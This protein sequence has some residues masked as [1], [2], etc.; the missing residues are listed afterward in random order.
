MTGK[1]LIPTSNAP[2]DELEELFPKFKQARIQD[3]EDALSELV[4]W[5]DD[6]DSEK[7]QELFSWFVKSRVIEYKAGTRKPEENIHEFLEIMDREGVKCRY[8]MMTHREEIICSKWEHN[9][10]IGLAEEN[11]IYQVEETVRKYKFPY[12]RVKKYIKL[13]ATPYHPAYDWINSKEW[14][15][16]DRFEELFNSLNVKNE[17]KELAKV[18]LW[19]WSLAGCRAILTQEGF[20]SENVLIF[21]GLQAAGKTKWLTGLAPLGCV[22]TG[23]QLN[24]SNKDSVLEATSVWIAELGEF[25]GTTSKSATAILKAFLSKRIDNI[26]KPYGI[27]EELIPRKTLFCGSVN[28]ESF[29][30]D[31]TG[32]RRYWVLETDDINHRHGIDMQQYWAQVMETALID[33]EEQP[34]WLTKEELKMQNFE[35]KKFRDLHPLCQKI[36]KI[37]NELMADKYHPSEIA[38]K[39]DVAVLKP[40][41][42]K[43][44]K[45]FM[46]SELG[47]TIQMR[48]GRQYWLINPNVYTPSDSEE[49][50]VPF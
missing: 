16:K 11:N 49:D 20:V 39:I 3:V 33:K 42:S 6:L 38:T 47:W 46:V 35:S 12:Q 23:L 7:A 45:Q 1:K 15:K 10:V 25:D 24:A 36:L 43:V 37:E 13:A 48:G 8:N 2:L 26:R 44:I 21:K 19:K 5:G 29:L 28:T 50:D 31:D 34:H 22:K 4:E 27:A 9:A 32:N 18:Y 17:N 30:V 41:E 14:D 40:H